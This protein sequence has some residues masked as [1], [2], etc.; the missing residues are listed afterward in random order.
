[1]G[2]TGRPLVFS[3]SADAL[4]GGGDWRWPGGGDG[5]DS[6]EGGKRKNFP[7]E[8]PR[9]SPECPQPAKEEGKSY[10]PEKNTRR[11]GG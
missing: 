7:S 11:N 2:Q 5:G 9:E 4:P 8:Q 3:A 6:N 1:M 10:R